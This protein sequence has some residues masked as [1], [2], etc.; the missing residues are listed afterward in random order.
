VSLRRSLRVVAA[1]VLEDRRVL[2]DRRPPG[3]ALAGTWEFPGGKVE[4]GEDDRSALAREIQ[5]ELGARAEI[6]DE[7]AQV[8]HVEGELELTLVLYRARLLQPPQALE[9]AELAWF[10]VD[11]LDA[12]PMPP[13]DRPLVARVRKL[14]ESGGA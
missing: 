6:L 9:V 13:A 7:V 4:A 1:L 2:L 3:K 10:S 8:T 5:E 12:L 14:L 11:A